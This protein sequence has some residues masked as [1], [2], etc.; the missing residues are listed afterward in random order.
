MG[1]LGHFCGRK[2][3]PI[4]NCDGNVIGEIPKSGKGLYKVV[5]D[6]GESSFAVT[7]KLTVME[8][9][10]RMGHISPG[11]AK[12][13]VDNGLVTGVRIIESSGDT[14]FCESCVYA[15]ATRKPVAKE[16]EGE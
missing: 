8:L 1:L 6:D 7:E 16:R 15:K 5:H 4:R 11:I 14:V 12:K 2:V 10:R 9:H 13:L 3:Y